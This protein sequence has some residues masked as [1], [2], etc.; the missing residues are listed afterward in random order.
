MEGKSFLKVAN[1]VN[2]LAALEVESDAE[3]E[4]PP[5]SI[6]LRFRELKPKA[7]KS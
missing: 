4:G 3:S 7:P 5:K 6:N 1:W 2:E